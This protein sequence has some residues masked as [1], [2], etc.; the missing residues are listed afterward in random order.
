MQ[1][2]RTFY[3]VVSQDAAIVAK[4][5]EVVANVLIIRAGSKEH[6]RPVWEIPRLRDSFRDLAELL[7]ES[8]AQDDPTV[9][10]IVVTRS[11]PLAIFAGTG[12]AALVTFSHV[13]YG[14]LI[15]ETDLDPDDGGMPLDVT[16]L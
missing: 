13:Q 5:L 12:R 3:T 4:G 11:G 6:S 2:I 10:E 8:T 9:V 14:T 1:N 15:G 7:V 16:E